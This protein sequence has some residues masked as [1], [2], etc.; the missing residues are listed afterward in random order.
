MDTTH[1]SGFF[2]RILGI[3]LHV[4][5]RGFSIDVSFSKRANVCG[6]YWLPKN[7]CEGFMN[8]LHS[9]RKEQSKTEFG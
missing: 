2:F 6:K 7:C 9:P 5:L 3:L 4:N 8:P 1:F